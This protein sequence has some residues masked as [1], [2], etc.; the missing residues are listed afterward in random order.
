[1]KDLLFLMAFIVTVPIGTALGIT[2]PLVQDLVFVGMI[3]GTTLMGGYLD[4]NFVSR[5][6]YKG[7]TRGIE[8]SS[9]D[10]LTL[11]LLLSVLWTRHRER[12]SLFWPAGLAW[13]LAYACYACAN[14]ALSTPKI[15]G[16]F[17]LT[18]IAR[19]IIVFLAV[20]YYVRGP[21]ELK[22]LLV[23][24]CLAI[25]HEGL[26]ALYQ[27]YLLHQFRIPGTLIHPNNLS[28]YCC[29]AAP[30]LVAGAFA[31]V[32][33]ALRLACAGC[34]VLAVACVILS[35]SR[36][37]FFVVMAVTTAALF[38][39]MGFRI[40]P[41]NVA[42]LVCAGFLASAMLWKSWDTISARYGQA[43]LEDEYGHEDQGRGVYLRLAKRIVSDHPLGV[44]LNNWSF[45]V[46]NQYGSQA[47]LIYNPYSGTNEWPD[48]THVHGM[49]DPQAVPAH[50]ILALTVG[51]LGWPGLFL[52]LGMWARWFILAGGPLLRRTSALDSCF[53]V[54]AFF[55]L[56]GIFLHG[57]TEY[58]FRVTPVFLLTH[59]VVGTMAA[60]HHH[61]HDSV[62]DLVWLSA[63]KQ[64]VKEVQGG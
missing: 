34:A 4:I 1:M 14:V 25:G 46:S 5:E 9:L 38:A 13:M 58:V 56:C 15:F 59:I 16:L 27:R 12:K 31:N 7:S 41:K 8:M 61:R 62:E 42:I 20:A 50:N 19:G 48:W 55:A 10:L 54:G 43:T 17:E 26:M 3:V 37:G 47:G 44:G 51:E 49:E 35:I 24:L 64:K 63:V 11:I 32:R 21:R 39:S 28:F 52:F 23:G 30:L 36:M 6:W 60:L 29:I 57:L 22:L 53:F 40:T 18:K 33:V 45:Y 2:V